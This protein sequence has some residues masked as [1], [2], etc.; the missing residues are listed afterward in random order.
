MVNWSL[1]KS[2]EIT[3]EQPSVGVEGGMARAWRQGRLGWWLKV[4]SLTIIG[5]KKSTTRGW[6][7]TTKSKKTQ[8]HRFIAMPISS[9]SIFLAHDRH[10]ATKVGQVRW[11]CKTL[12]QMLSKV[13]TCLKS[14]FLFSW[15]LTMLVQIVKH[16]IWK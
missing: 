16:A 10:G 14:W 2:E 4:L 13:P 11:N 7:P 6:P 1:Y 15:S 9:V 12:S 3:L 8:E 5:D